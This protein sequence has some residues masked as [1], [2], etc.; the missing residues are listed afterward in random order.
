LRGQGM[1][2]QRRYF[3]LI[4]GYNYRLTNVACALLCGQLERRKGIVA[5]RS[6]IFRQYTSRLRDI[7]GIG[8]QP[9]AE[10]A[11]PA[12]W[13]YCITVE[14][15]FG[16]SRDD[17]ALRLRQAGID[18]RPFFVPIHTLPPYQKDRSLDLPITNHLARTGLNLPTFP[19]V[20]AMEIDRICSAIEAARK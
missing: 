10:W 7:P 9:V 8:L 17:L 18:T 2:P 5:R 20:T 11:Q 19:F 3:F 16:R 14:S 13:L 1:D 15:G 12:H 4:I 6:E